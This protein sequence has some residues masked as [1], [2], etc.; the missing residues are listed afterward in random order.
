MDKIEIKFDFPVLIQNHDTV[1]IH[2][3]KLHL[4]KETAVITGLISMCHVTTLHTEILNNSKGSGSL[5]CSEL[6]FSDNL[7]QHKTHKR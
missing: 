7:V 6:H 2:R 5:R 3:N 1:K 4:C